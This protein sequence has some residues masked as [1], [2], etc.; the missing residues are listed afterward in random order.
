M[1]RIFTLLSCMAAVCAASWADT[2]QTVTVGGSVVEKFV[3]GIT[4]SGDNAVLAFDDGTGQTADMSLV[5]I[6]LT[7]GDGGGDPAAITEVTAHGAETTKVYTISGQMVGRST[8]GLP[9]GLY[10]V[11]GKKV[12][13]K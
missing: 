10:I 7:Y 1:K 3:T 4:F 13:I 11:N 8:E 12:I 9:R 5:S 2:G 6:D